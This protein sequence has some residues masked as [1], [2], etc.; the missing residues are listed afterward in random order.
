MKSLV[1]VKYYGCHAAF[2]VAFLVLIKFVANF[3]YYIQIAYAIFVLLPIILY[4]YVIDCEKCH[5]SIYGR[6]KGDVDQ[7]SFNYIFIK[8]KCPYCNLDRC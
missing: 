3:N 5:K 8:K 2:Y 1:R 7:F 4:G 6:G